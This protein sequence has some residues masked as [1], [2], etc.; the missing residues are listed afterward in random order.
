MKIKEFFNGK[1]NGVNTF[2]GLRYTEEE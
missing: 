1:F 2:I